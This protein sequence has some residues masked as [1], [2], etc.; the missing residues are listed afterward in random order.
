MRLLLFLPLFLLL[1]CSMQKRKYQKGFYVSWNK[2]KTHVVAKQPI[3]DVKSS[4]STDFV[5]M[6]SVEKTPNQ[7]S[8]GFKQH[9]IFLA[10]KSK[11]F[12]KKQEP[13]TCDYV[14]FKNGEE[15]KAKVFEITPDEIK[16]RRCDGTNTAIYVTRKTDVFMIKYANG[17]KEVFKDQPKVTNDSYFF[18]GNNNDTEV[19]TGAVLSLI[20]GIAGFIL[21]FG[22]IP[23]IVLGVNA[24]KDINKKPEKYSGSS[25]AKAGIALGITK[26]VL[27][28]LIIAV[29]T[30][31][32]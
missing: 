15:V 3:K 24:L 17:I 26:L 2:H 1:S 4:E 5:T 25:L 18:T 21:F 7:S 13:D 12:F 22:S 14:I 23:A 6:A 9:D 29:L 31:F 16:Y 32:A 11:L 19:H 10:P 8:H 30:L 20:F 27:L 28:V